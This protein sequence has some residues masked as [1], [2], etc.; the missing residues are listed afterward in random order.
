MSS[1]TSVRVATDVGG[2]FTDM[3]FIEVGADGSQRTRTA[4][5]ETTPPH[6]EEGV[7]NVLERGAV[8]VTEVGFLA[9]GTTVV[10]NALTE[11]KGAVIGYFVGQVMKASK[12]KANPQKVNE[13]LKRVL[14]L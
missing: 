9:H 2:T 14:S 12:G 4:K 6:F 11:R 3:A 7:L 8:D 5:V 1:G 10:I 13:L